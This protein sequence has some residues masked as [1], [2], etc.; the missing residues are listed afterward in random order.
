MCFWA[1][2]SCL[3]SLSRLWEGRGIKDCGRLKRKVKS[4]GC[5]DMKEKTFHFSFYVTR[6]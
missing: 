1:A 6:R 2:F 5:M 4:L 3:F